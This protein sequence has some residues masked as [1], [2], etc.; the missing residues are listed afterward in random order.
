M[1]VFYFISNFIDQTNQLKKH[2]FEDQVNL[3][4]IC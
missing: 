1:C 4:K 2:I 3:R